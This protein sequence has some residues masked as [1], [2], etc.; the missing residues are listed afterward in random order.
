MK[1]SGDKA[2]AANATRSSKAKVPR[3]KRSEVD[4]KTERD[5]LEELVAAGYRAGELVGLFSKSLGGTGFGVVT[6]LDE[7]GLSLECGDV[8]V[9]SDC[10]SYN[11][12]VPVVVEYEGDYTDEWLPY[13]FSLSATILN[14][15]NSKKAKK[16]FALQGRNYT[17]TTKAMSKAKGN[18][19]SLSSWSG[20]QT[21]NHTNR[22]RR[23]RI[24]KIWDGWQ[25]AFEDIEGDVSLLGWEVGVEH[26][27]CEANELVLKLKPPLPRLGLFEAAKTNAVQH[28]RMLGKGK[29]KERL[30]YHGS[31]RGAVVDIV[32]RGL[33]N[34]SGEQHG[35]A[36]GEGYY[37]S[38]KRSIAIH[39]APKVDNSRYTLEAR[40][41]TCERSSEQHPITP[42]GAKRSESLSLCE[43]GGNG[44]EI[45]CVWL[46]QAC[47]VLPSR[48]YIRKG[49]NS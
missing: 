13:S 9:L 41:L 39:Y 48:V 26:A 6:V 32:C 23:V 34:Y 8:I 24:R 33:V 27:R 15:I 44:H 25:K 46:H 1:K 37:F 35:K 31:S 20:S 38:T 7:D 42:S 22:Q 29:V 2:A 43:T 12:I 49:A 36:Y 16:T 4:C 30:L 3:R 18:V 17:V 40:V 45:V 5:G 47:N 14:A 11:G 21:N 10:L 28:E 19:S